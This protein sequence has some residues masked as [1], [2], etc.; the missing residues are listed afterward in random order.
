MTAT[1]AR[2]DDILDEVTAGT[3]R[4]SEAYPRVSAVID[5]RVL[6]R[7]TG[8]RGTIS[9]FTGDSVELCDARGARHTFRNLPGAFAVEGETV[10]LVRPTGAG[11]AGTT[12]AVRRSASGAIVEV[13]QRAQVAR[14]SRLW[15]EGD[16]DARLVERVWGDELREMAVVVEPMGGLDDLVAEV[17]RFSPG[18]GRSLVVLADH[19][20]A[21]SKES[22][23]AA[24]VDSP[25]V[26]VVGHPFVDIWECVRP[27]SLGIERWPTVP[28]PTDWKTGVCETLGWGTPAE[29]WRRVL[30]AVEDFSDLDAC[31]IRS[32]EEALDHFAVEAGTV[33][34]ADGEAAAGTAGAGE[35]GR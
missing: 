17:R 24:A 19:L 33:G 12:P 34:G 14:A 15:V 27:S 21:G 3:K 7:G 28:P 22:R 29:G 2:V 1:V 5:L 25:H 23:I 32:M 26:L 9:R 8:K 18:P 6:H 4:P 31:L 20:V 35:R 11:S 30:A 16:H 13:E 10:T